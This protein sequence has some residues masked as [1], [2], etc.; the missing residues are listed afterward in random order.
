MEDRKSSQ[1]EPMVDERDA[2]E[3][4]HAN[5]Q[6]RSSILHPPSS[7]LRFSQRSL[8][9]FLICRR[10]FQLR[11]L[12]RLIWP[13]PFSQADQELEA[14]MELGQNFHQAVHQ[15]LVGVDPAELIAGNTDGRL[16][17]WWQDF[18]THVLPRLPDGERWPEANLSVPMG[19]AWL[20]AR[21]D[22]LTVSPSGEATIFDWKTG[23]PPERD[24]LARHMQTRVYPFVL[25]EAGHS[26]HHDQPIP[27]DRIKMAYW[28][29]Q[30]PEHLIELPYSQTTHE[31]NRLELQALIDEI[32]SLPADGFPKVA[33]LTP[34]RR[35]NYRAYCGR[36][37]EPAPAIELVDE[38]VDWVMEEAAAYEIEEDL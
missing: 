18:E 12:D 36:E 7:I 38:E 8:A 9:D 30:S 3:A 5:S 33:D 24:E 10:R 14:L 31:R 22:L 1:M 32:V 2:K 34:C 29:A 27:P 28:F 26:Y 19:D 11:Y 16:A 13:A 21:L 25:A 20:V 37:V 23:Q 6:S 15:V 35:C 4:S 17:T